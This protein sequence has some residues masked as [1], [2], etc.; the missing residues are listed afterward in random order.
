MR[1]NHLI[2][3]A[4]IVGIGIVLVA[5]FLYSRQEVQS[6]KQ[7]CEAKNLQVYEIGDQQ[8]CRDHDTGALYAP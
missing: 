5:M 3:A 4:I 8:V 6:F 2:T 1:R 7:K